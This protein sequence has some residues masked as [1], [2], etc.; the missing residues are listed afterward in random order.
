V[1]RLTDFFP[2]AGMAVLLHEHGVTISPSNITLVMS[3]S[4]SLNDGKRQWQV[5]LVEV[6]NG[7][8]NVLVKG[9]RRPERIY[10]L[11]GFQCKVEKLLSSRIA[12]PQREDLE[13][14]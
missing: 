2:V 1:I 10:A 5:S 7:E 13:L 3:R 12:S 6:L 9:L 8:L 11:E 4:T 14:K